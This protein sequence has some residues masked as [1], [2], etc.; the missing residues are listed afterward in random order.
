MAH[1]YKPI[2]GN[3]GCWLTAGKL[4][5]L[6]ETQKLAAEYFEKYKAE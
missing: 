6:A 2:T 3:L 4:E 1:Q 5:Q